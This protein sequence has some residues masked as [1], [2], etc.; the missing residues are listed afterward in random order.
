MWWLGNVY[1]F[2]DHQ[3]PF[4]F[5]VKATSAFTLLQRCAKPLWGISDQDI[6]IAWMCCPATAGS[7]IL[8]AIAQ[9]TPEQSPQLCAQ[10]DSTGWEQ[11]APNDGAEECSGTRASNTA[12][13]RR[14]MV[15]FGFHESSSL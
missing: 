11:N 15:S 13:D 9:A 14:V 12:E 3:G 7:Q 1:F 10:H 2:C 6:L 8:R 5:V 4:A